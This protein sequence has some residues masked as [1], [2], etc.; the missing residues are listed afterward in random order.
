MVMNQ[1][2]SIYPVQLHSATALANVQLNDFPFMVDNPAMAYR[3]ATLCL[4][5]M[6]KTPTKEQSAALYTCLRISGTRTT[7]L[8]REMLD[9]S[10]DNDAPL[11]M[12]Y[13]QPWL[14]E[15]PND[16]FRDV[17]GWREVFT[18]WR[19]DVYAV[20][21]YGERDYFVNGKLHATYF[22][23]ITEAPQRPPRARAPPPRA[24]AAAAA[25]PA[26]WTRAQPPHRRS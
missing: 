2:D 14:N 26:A 7:P 6:G 25:P 8:V 9:L 5:A 22:A 15:A 24:A 17:A 23:F 13:E 21:D 11:Y 10:D 1:A 12:V 4:S 16:Y 20:V 19:S 18:A 3:Y